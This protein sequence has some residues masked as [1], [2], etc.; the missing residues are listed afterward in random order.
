MHLWKYTD[1]AVVGVLMCVW[2]VSKFVQTVSPV[3]D[4]YMLLALGYVF[5][6]I[7]QKMKISKEDDE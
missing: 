1:D 6:N 4:E 2:A 5:G 3:E 7:V